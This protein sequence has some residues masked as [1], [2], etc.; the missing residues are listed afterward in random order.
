MHYVQD[1]ISPQR[2]SPCELLLPN[3]I[4]TFP[5]APANSIWFHLANHLLPSCTP[6]GGRTLPVSP[7]RVYL[8]Q[9]N[10]LNI[11]FS[12]LPLSQSHQCQQRWAWSTAPTRSGPFEA[13]DVPHTGA[14]NNFRAQHQQIS[15]K[16]QA[17]KL[18]Q[19]KDAVLFLQEKMINS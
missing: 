12:V 6:C 19:T 15:C 5:F 10:A 14:D 4:P 2:C 8:F 7:A 3:Q 17:T 13:P 9:N 16:F 1:W 18:E 11:I